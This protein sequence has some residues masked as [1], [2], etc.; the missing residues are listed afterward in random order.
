MPQHGHVPGDGWGVWPPVKGAGV[1]ALLGSEARKTEQDSRA[2]EI[3]QTTVW[4]SL[5]GLF[6]G[7]GCVVC[8]CVFAGCLG[9]LSPLTS[10]ILASGE[11]VPSAKNKK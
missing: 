9:C 7:G 11:V 3:H 1:G 5:M 6:Y 8:F 2:G 10:R 4:G